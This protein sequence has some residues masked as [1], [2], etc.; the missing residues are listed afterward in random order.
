M[1]TA[2]LKAE[3]SRRGTTCFKYAMDKARGYSLDREKFFASPEFKKFGIKALSDLISLPKKAGK[4]ALDKAGE[5]VIDKLKGDLKKLGKD[6]TKKA[7]KKLEKEIK[8]ALKLQPAEVMVQNGSWTTGYATGCN[9]SLR[10]VWNKKTSTYSYLIVSNCACE[11]DEDTGVEKRDQKKTK[12]LIAT[13]SGKV[14]VTV[15][16]K[17]VKF[18]PGRPSLFAQFQ[19]CG[20]SRSVVRSSKSRGHVVK[21]EKPKKPE[22]GTADTKPKTPPKPK[23]KILRHK[24]TLKRGE[25]SA[26]NRLQPGDSDAVMNGKIKKYQERI[27]KAK[28]EGELDEIGREMGQNVRDLNEAK[29]SG[30][31][32]AKDAIKKLE[33]VLPELY[34]KQDELAEKTDW[35]PEIE[36]LLASFQPADLLYCPRDA[37]W[38]ELIFIEPT[39]E[40]FVSRE[41]LGFQTVL[42]EPEVCVG[43]LYS[44][45]VGEGY[46]ETT[47]T[48]RED[49]SIVLIPPKKTPTP[50]EPE[51]PTP[52]EPDQP[53]EPTGN[54]PEPTTSTTENPSEPKEP[55]EPVADVPEVPDFGLVKAT[56]TVVELALTGDSNANN[57]ERAVIKLLPTAPALPL[58]ANTE[59][60]SD[61]LEDAAMSALGFYESDVASGISDENGAVLINA[62]FGR[63]LFDNNTPNELE[64]LGDVS[65]EEAALFETFEEDPDEM[66]DGERMADGTLVPAPTKDNLDQ[67]PNEMGDGERMADGEK[68]PATT[69]PEPRNTAETPAGETAGRSKAGSTSSGDPT[70]GRAV[71]GMPKFMR[72]KLEPAVVS[73]IPAVVGLDPSIENPD[74]QLS[75]LLN[76][77]GAGGSQVSR[78][79]SIGEV[80]I[81]I[82]HV[83]SSRS[84]TVRDYLTA[85]G[86]TLFVEDDPCRNKEQSD[87]PHFNGTGLWNQDFDNQ[88]AI[89]RVGFTDQDNSA[90]DAIE[91]SKLAPVTVAVIDTGIDWFHPD[92]ARSS[93]WSNEK[94]IPG[95]GI[96]DDQNGYID[97][98]IGWD[99]VRSNNKPWDHDGHGTFVAGVIAATN[100]NG[101]GIKG[102][103]PAAKIMVLKALDELG[104]GHASMISEA[105]VYA[106]NNGAKI[107]NLSLGGRGI[108]QMERL[109]VKHAQNKGALVVVAAGNSGAAAANY[110]P[111][112]LDGVVTV[113]ATDRNDKRAGFSNW[114]PA[115]NIAAPGVDVLSLRG[116]DTDL[117]AHIPDVKYEVGQ[118]IVGEDRAYF[119]ASGTSFAAPIVAGTASYLLSVFPD[120][121]ADELRRMLLNSAD[122]IDTPGVDN[123]TGH[124]LLNA[125]AAL[126]AD[127]DFFVEARVSGVKAVQRNGKVYLQVFGTADADRFSKAN[128]LVG[129]GKNPERWLRVKKALPQ[130]SKPG[131]LIELPGAALAKSKN[132]VLRLIVEHKDGTEKQSRFLLTLG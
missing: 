81:Y 84:A 112:G 105:I 60:A 27:R 124:G 117:L 110:A 32:G 80:P 44:F 20:D 51:G 64:I 122:D 55:E 121:S 120:L 43:T 19:C 29:G 108:T 88:W 6:L 48:V 25:D 92:L 130:L 125:T 70:I 22:T 1:I 3:A 31:A 126:A 34:K 42:R 75:D 89:K 100:D 69:K 33:K 93:L 103:N 57:I 18:R 23:V 4:D 123:Y 62:E 8:E 118:G 72:F 9:I 119:R 66:G 83:N 115:V 17:T 11:C 37:W 21:P 15:D 101:I 28:T 129:S 39:E 131:L 30:K 46:R 106:A 24:G 12:K 16:G 63:G 58:F 56:E 67:D 45:V 10:I 94:E 78:K 104:Q 96:D 86:Y 90:V 79:F 132:W 116:R 76:K 71:N 74:Q 41:P 127:P 49:P 68:V 113:A 2:K 26:G 114:G 102:I 53:N 111:A 7:E 99:F 91:E 128:L 95:N 40:I 54:A 73:T 97:D 35:T 65:E 98:L 59:F 107:I 50:E 47:T 52:K 38:S 85:S 13:G 5:H 14:N 109:A 77:A 61:E 36:E 87:D 82:V